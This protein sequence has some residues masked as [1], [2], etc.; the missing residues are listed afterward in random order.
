MLFKSQFPDVEIPQVSVYDYLFGTLTPDDLAEVAVVDGPTELTYGELRARVD[1]FAGALAARGVRPGD[2][3]ALHAPNCA[4]WVV[5]FHGILRAGATATTINSLYTPAEI[6]GQLRDSGAKRYVTVSLLLPAA[7]AAVAEVGLGTGDVITLDEVEG[8][9][10]MAAMLREGAPAPDVS[11]DPA[12][13]LAVLPYSSGTTGRAKGV[14]LTHRNLV[15]NIAQCEPMLD[16]RPDDV[17]LAV[18]PFFHIY[19]MNALMNLALRVRARLVTMLR[20]DLTEFLTLVQEQRCTYLFIAP[21]VAVALAKHPAVDQFDVSTVRAIISGAAP[22][23]EALGEAL[24]A[25]LGCGMLQGYGMT[26]LSPV[27]HVVPMS[28]TDLSIGSIGLSLPNVEFKVVDPAT[29]DEIDPVEGGR[30]APGELWVRS[31]GVMKGYLGNE[32]ATH[33]TIDDDGFLHTGDIV[34]VGAQGEVYVVDRLKELIK[35]KGYQVPPAELEAVLLTHPDI[36]DVAVVAHPDEESGEVPHAFV[37]PQE[38][39]ELTPEDVMAYVAE[40]VAPHK[41]VRLV[42]FIA[43]V[44]KSA[45]G[46]IL[47]KD[48][49]GRSAADLP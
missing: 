6:A 27:S 39:A 38:G 4:A 23:D 45:S 10:S 14:M 36:A 19:G 17:V 35:Y 16:V 34:E 43:A 48:L 32:Q 8:H 42:S 3:V 18:L 7:L 47:R 29:G 46:K 30:S 49:K 37:V 28:R 26:E 31:P 22:L 41:K 5:A 1:A 13:H 15:A 24:K 40:R 21:P 12:T 20:F 9:E 44:P 11:F 25:R 2:V 33:D